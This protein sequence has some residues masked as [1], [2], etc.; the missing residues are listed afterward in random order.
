MKSK[1]SP[2]F[3]KRKEPHT[4]IIAHGNSISHFTVRPWVAAV[5]G[6]VFAAM[7]IGYLVATSYLVLRDDLIGAAAARQ[8]RI[9]EAYEDRIS[10]LRAQVDRIA[11]RDFL[12]QKLMEQ[13]VAELIK[14]QQTLTQRRSRMGPLLDRA[15]ALVPAQP[16]PAMPDTPVPEERPDRHA[17]LLRTDLIGANGNPDY[18]VSPGIDPIITGDPGTHASSP[19]GESA[20]DRADRVFAG[21]GKAL[22]QIENN[23]FGRIRTLT[24]TAHQTANAIYAALGRTGV[25]LNKE[26][27]GVGGPL[28]PIPSPSAKAPRKGE[29]AAKFDT[30]LAA[31]DTALD[32]LDAAKALARKVPIATPVPPEGVSSP[33]GARTDPMLGTPAFHPGL[34]LR[35]TYGTPIH[36]TGDGKVVFAGRDG[37][38][39]NMVE[40]DH[41]NGLKTRYGHMSKILVT[42]GQTVREGQVIGKVGSTGRSTGPHLHYEVRVDGRPVDPSVFLSAGRAISKIL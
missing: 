27:G 40:I 12:D 6:S 29:A 37:G 17:S 18:A 24:N 25:P 31:L 23:Q 14:R 34:D 21:I 13:K 20:A 35:A 33:F 2:I 22:H 39:G 30:E 42:T 26:K 38:Y 1:A 9:Q 15:A 4:I 36:A 7:A 8:A 5:V 19:S 32:R 41:G 11:S 3:G 10:A 28:V 16:M